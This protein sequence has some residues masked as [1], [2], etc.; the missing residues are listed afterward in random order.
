MSRA[1][2]EAAHKA[3][4]KKPLNAYFQFRAEKLIEYKDDEKRTEKVKKEWDG[5]SEAERGKLDAAYKLELENYKKDFAEWK[6]K[7]SVSDKDL[8]VIKEREKS[9]KKGD[10]SK[11]K[12]TKVSAK[13][14]NK[15]DKEA[16]KSKEKAEKNEK[17]KDAKAEKKTETAKE[18]KGKD[19]KKNAKSK[20]KN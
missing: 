6:E 19:E 10:K 4:P 14:E 9:M 20:G 11:G 16:S 3:M 13:K 2:N 15:N 5:M 1:I 12:T 7:Y 8:E 18:N 17:G